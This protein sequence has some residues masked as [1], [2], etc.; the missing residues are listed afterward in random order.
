M[1]KKDYRLDSMPSAMCHVVIKRYGETCEEQAISV[2]LWSYYTHVLTIDYHADD[3]SFDLHASGTYSV[4]T[5]RHINRFTKEFLG[6]NLYHSVKSVCSKSDEEFPLVLALDCTNNK[7]A[8][9][10]FFKALERYSNYGKR[11]Y[12][13]TKSEKERFNAHSWGW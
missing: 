3:Q 6:E 4:T 12:D 5:A 7:T 13:Y 9:Q 11:F 10:A 8:E 2:E 1:E